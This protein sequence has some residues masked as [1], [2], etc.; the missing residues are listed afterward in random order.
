LK[1]KIQVY[2]SSTLVALDCEMQFYAG[3]SKET[4]K[5]LNTKGRQVLAFGTPLYRFKNE[6]TLRCKLFE[7]QNKWYTFL[8][9]RK[10]LS[11]F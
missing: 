2:F 1:K 3:K 9:I 4:Y 5:L 7:Q 8:I 11:T 6:K 10:Q